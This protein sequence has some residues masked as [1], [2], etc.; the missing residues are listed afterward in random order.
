MFGQNTED[1]LDHWE[2]NQVKALFR[3]Y[4]KDKSGL[5]KEQLNEIMK[6]LLDDECIIGKVPLLN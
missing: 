1:K 6:K 3:E 5:V 4:D 2:K